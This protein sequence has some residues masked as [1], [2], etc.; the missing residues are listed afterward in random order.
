[1]GEFPARPSAKVTE[2]KRQSQFTAPKPEPPATG[3]SEP[4]SGSGLTMP[5]IKNIRWEFKKGP[6]SFEAWYV[7]PGAPRN[8]KGKVS[9]EYCDYLGNICKSKQLELAKLPRDEFETVVV[10]W[11]KEQAAKK[12]IEL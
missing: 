2:P 4:V 3:Y 11:V 12:G 8:S 5:T 9:R 6:Q 7:P 10:E 1:M